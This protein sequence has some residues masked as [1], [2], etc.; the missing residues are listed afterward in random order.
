MNQNLKELSRVKTYYMLHLSY[1]PAISIHIYNNNIQPLIGRFSN[2]QPIT[3]QLPFNYQ[4]SKL[5]FRPPSAPSDSGYYKCRA[6]TTDSTVIVDSAA[7]YIGIPRKCRYIVIM[8]TSFL[9]YFIVNGWNSPLYA[10]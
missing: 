2:Y 5:F 3:S 1:Q 9:Y 4:V 10:K 8:V 6:I 7:H